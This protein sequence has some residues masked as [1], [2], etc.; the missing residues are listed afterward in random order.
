MDEKMMEMHE[1]EQGLSAIPYIFDYEVIDLRENEWCEMLVTTHMTD[2][3]NHSLEFT[4][5]IFTDFSQIYGALSESIKH[6]P[7]DLADYGIDPDTLEF[8]FKTYDLFS[9]LATFLES[10]LHSQIY[11]IR[12]KN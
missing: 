5:E 4:I 11:T 2:A 7:K 8:D 3:Q 12:S 10:L 6:I 1:I 9:D